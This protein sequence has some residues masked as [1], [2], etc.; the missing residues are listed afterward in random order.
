MMYKL[1]FDSQF[2]KSAQKLDRNLKPRLKSSL[3]VLSENP[4]QSALHTKALSGRLA[5]YYSFRQGRDYRVIFK[6]IPDGIIYLLKVGHRSD[7]Y[8]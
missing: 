2:L 4:F 3:D 8:K 1:V 7:I 6:F 5:G